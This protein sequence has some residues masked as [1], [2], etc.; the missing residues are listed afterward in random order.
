MRNPLRTEAEA[1]RFLLVTIAGAIV[2]V[3]CAYANTWLGVAA[4]VL[5]LGGIV[6]WLRGGP[7]TVVPRM[8]ARPAGNYR[9]L[10]VAPAETACDDLREKLKARLEDRDAEVLVVVPAP[11]PAEEAARA[12]ERLASQL[13]GGGLRARGAAGAGDPVLAAED[14][15]REFGADEVVLADADEFLRSRAQD[16]LTVPVSLLS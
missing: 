16:R 12:A 3:G 4:A 13:S 9:I 1:F 15:L 5:V 2:I 7:S 14:A 8:P 11:P 6:W 10:V